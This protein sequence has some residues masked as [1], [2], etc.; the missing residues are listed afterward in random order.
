MAIVLFDYRAFVERYLEFS[1]TSIQAASGAFAD[2]TLYLDNTDQSVVQDIG[3]RSSLL[4]MLVAHLLKIAT[5]QLV[6]RI[7]GASEGSV[8]VST[9]FHGPGSMWWYNSTIY[10][11]SFVQATAKY[12][13][14][15]YVPPQP[16][17]AP[18]GF[19]NG[20]GGYAPWS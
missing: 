17:R 8:S 18:I 2:A 16:R 9:E 15:R 13:T 3:Q 5:M 12:R 20:P 7:S 14:G 10:G 4:N 1:T 19:W 6:G 11:A